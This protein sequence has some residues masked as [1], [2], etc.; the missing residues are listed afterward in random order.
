M[1]HIDIDILHLLSASTRKS[2]FIWV[3]ISSCS[4][5]IDVNDQIWKQ[6]LAQYTC[7][8]KPLP[9]RFGRS[10]HTRPDQTVGWS[11]NCPNTLSCFRNSI[12]SLSVASLAAA[13]DFAE[14]PSD[15]SEGWKGSGWG[16][17]CQRHGVRSRRVLGLRSLSPDGR[18][19]ACRVKDQVLGERLPVRK[20]TPKTSEMITK[21]PRRCQTQC[22]RERRP[23][24]VCLRFIL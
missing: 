1:P 8:N 7:Q 2:N 24:C 4:R 6:P 16:L 13:C 21:P 12:Q 15:Q 10:P 22:K 5:L 20:P 19:E 14:A 3:T 18:R 23:V 9:R 11:T 17:A